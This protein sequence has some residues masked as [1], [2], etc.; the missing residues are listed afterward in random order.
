[1]N[2]IKYL[3]FKYKLNSNHRKSSAEALADKVAFFILIAI[4]TAIVYFIIKLFPQSI[5][6][7]M[8]QYAMGV[9]AFVYVISLSSAVKKYYK[10]YFLA[11]EREILLIAP[12]RNSQIILSRF[13]IVAFDV[14]VFG[15]I[16]L[17][18][19]VTA[20]Y[21]AGNIH[22]GIVLITI[23]QVLAVA[24]V[25][26]FFAHTLFAFAY[27]F[28]RGKGLKTAA[29]TLVVIASVGVIA[30]IVFW[31]NYKSFF[32][33]Q[34]HLLKGIFHV[35]FK[36]PEYMLANQITGADI[37]IFSLVSI[38]NML[39]LLFL[40]FSLT[41]FCYKKGLL[42][43]SSRDLEKS[44]YI[45]KL[46]AFL[47]KHVENAFL[48]KDILYL[49]RSPKLFSVYITP[50]LF[51]SILE[52]RIQFASLGVFFSIFISVFIAIIVS[53][54]LNV[55]QTDDLNHKNLLFSIP[56]DIENL[57]KSRI[58]LL[59]TLSTLVAGT[60]ITFICLVESV[61]WEYLFFSLVQLLFMTYISSKVLVSRVIHKSNKNFSGYR[62]NGSL[63][64]TIFYYMLVWNIPLLILFSFLS[65]FLMYAVEEG[66]TLSL[67]TGGI[68]IVV[69][70]LVLAMFYRSTR[71]HINQPKEN[72]V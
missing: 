46:S 40:A 34:D 10:E 24:I 9:F 30:I 59:F 5:Q 63:A 16:F 4:V 38:A 62:Y 6:D 57:F 50:I 55:L 31:Q 68:L 33:V 2:F 26:S 7:N 21:F 56:F 64:G 14:L 27:M 47:N 28:T 66:F 1:M 39:I 43:V 20:N 72:H 49:I 3:S 15:C 12:I 17:L 19:F 61:R 60:F 53:I 51:T 25:S 32:L 54:T 8:N 58:I 13:F 48:K 11:P 23:P 29:Y 71:I 35:L 37:G 22:F 45:S 36:Y 42:S 41:S 69:C 52:I 44:F 70:L 18:P 65:G 67:Y